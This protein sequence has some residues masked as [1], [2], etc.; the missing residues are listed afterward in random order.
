M[1]GRSAGEAEQPLLLR[2]VDRQVRPEEH[3]A[4]ELPWLVTL[5]DRFNDPRADPGDAQETREMGPATSLALADLVQA[6]FWVG[7]NQL[8]RDA[9]VANSSARLA[10]MLLMPA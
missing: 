7:V 2:P 4:A 5:C 1:V 8:Q 6:E 10:P 3:L 9:R